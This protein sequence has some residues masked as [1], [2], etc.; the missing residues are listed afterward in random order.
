[1]IISGQ[2]KL[3]HPV[4]VSEKL[5]V[6]EGRFS[7]ADTRRVLK[8]MGSQTNRPL[9]KGCFPQRIKTWQGWDGRVHV[10]IYKAVYKHS[11]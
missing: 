2:S 8:S 5:R 11:C 3:E 4:G 7:F 1:M 9:V 10:A 6:G